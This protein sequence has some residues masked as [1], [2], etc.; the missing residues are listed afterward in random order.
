MQ[1]G[2]PRRK[3]ANGDTNHV[4]F[5]TMGTTSLVKKQSLPV[6]GDSFLISGRGDHNG[7]IVGSHD[8]DTSGNLLL[9]CFCNANGYLMVCPVCAF[10]CMHACAASSVCC[11]YYMYTPEFIALKHESGILRQS[12]NPVCGFSMMEQVRLCAVWP[13]E[14]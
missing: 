8:D 9:Y 2:R 3:M 10:I 4:C 1:S 14:N 13:I 11:Y 5:S 6:I 7:E 12:S